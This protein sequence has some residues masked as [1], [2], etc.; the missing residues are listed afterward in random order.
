M[1]TSIA[2]RYEEPRLMKCVGGTALLGFALMLGLV[3]WVES[4]PDPAN[5]GV[6]DTMFAVMMVPM[7]AIF[8]VPAL[9]LFTH[10]AILEI[11]GGEVKVTR[12]ALGFLRTKALPNDDSGIVAIETGLDVSR[13]SP[14]TIWRVMYRRADKELFIRQFATQEEAQLFARRVAQRLAEGL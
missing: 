8:L 3:A 12:G 7:I 13:S 5:G 2:H 14:R 1:E 10:R 4:R 11:E 6:P 9:I